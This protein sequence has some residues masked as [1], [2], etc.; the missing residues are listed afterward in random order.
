MMQPPSHIWVLV[1]VLVGACATSSPPAMEPVRAAALSLAEATALVD[2]FEAGR[3]PPAQRP[4]PPTTMAEAVGVLKSD[5]LDLFPGAVDLLSTQHT[6][7]AMALRAQILLAW[8]EAELTIAEILAN[9]ADKLDDGIRP[10]Q[11]RR[12]SD[13][14]AARLAAERAKI[15]GYRDTDQALRLLAAE[16]VAAGDDEAHKLMAAK[17]ND[18]AGY[19]VAADAHRLRSEWERFGDMVAKLQERNPDSNGLVFLRGIAA[20][21]RDGDTAQAIVCYRQ[22]LQNDPQFIRAQA[23]LVLVQ[24]D[25]L[26]Q[27]AELDR[28]REIAPDHQIVRWAGPDIDLAYT[29]VRQRQQAPR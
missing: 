13:E 2:A 3:L 25:I 15:A 4:P 27:K 22:A 11:M 19:R 9:T 6:P 20:H 12:L 8:G 29:R 17:P 10:S 1:A 23:Q 16:H 21:M 5:R 18:Y 26:E 14:E 24:T 7:E 28:L